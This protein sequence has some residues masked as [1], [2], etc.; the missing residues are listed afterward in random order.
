MTTIVKFLI[1]LLLGVLLTNCKADFNSSQGFKGNGKVITKKRE[2]YNSFTKI[3]ASEGL[4]IF[5]T[6]DIKN[7]IDVQAD[8]NIHQYI[9]TE[10]IDGTLELAFII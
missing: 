6:Q 3:K 4:E 5:L 9:I 1:T 10:V 2:V 8:E 7:S